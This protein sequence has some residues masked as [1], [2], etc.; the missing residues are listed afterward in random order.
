MPSAALI[1]GGAQLF[2]RA[3][4]ISKTKEGRMNSLK[5]AI[6]TSALALAATAGATAHAQSLP[7]AASSTQA[8]AG[9][10]TAATSE[11]TEAEVRKVDK[12]TKKITLKHGAIKNLDMP[13]M[14]M[15]FQVSD[16]AILEK[17][18]VGDKVRFKAT[19]EG[20]KYTVT[21]LQTAK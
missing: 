21:E 6:V 11:M 15:V 20:G 19:G 7:G 18:Q 16:A 5:H 17:V 1:S 3:R 10:G 14:T 13:P 4:I 2:S 9:S 8:S 12:E